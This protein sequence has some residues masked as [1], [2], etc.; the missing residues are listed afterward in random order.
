MVGQGQLLI[1]TLWRQCSIWNDRHDIQ[2]YRYPDPSATPSP[3]L[4]RLERLRLLHAQGTAAS[5]TNAPQVRS[6]AIDETLPSQLIARRAF[7]D[8]VAPCKRAASVTNG[9]GQADVPATEQP[10]HASEFSS[11]MRGSIQHS[12]HRQP[13]N[14][15][16][17]PINLSVSRPRPLKVC[18]GNSGD[19]RLRDEDDPGLSSEH[20]RAQ[21]CSHL[22]R[23]LA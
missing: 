16:A 23:C 15:S 17:G 10:L 18:G 4:F 6:I 13:F 21:P 8:K 19:L 5:A 7:E 22:H 9:R 3:I 11:I 20:G 12:L 14:E 1:A 2:Q